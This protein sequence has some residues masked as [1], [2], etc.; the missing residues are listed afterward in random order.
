MGVYKFLKKADEL[1]AKHQRNKEEKP[2][3]ENGH[4]ESNWLVSY[5]DMMTLL[6]GFFI[7]LFSMAKIDETKYEVVK[8]EMAKQFKGSY[9]APA[10]NDIA[11]FIN[12]II[13][14]AKLD[15]HAL[16]TTDPTGV[17]VVFQATL[18]FDTLSSEVSA[19][20]RD[21][22]DRLIE[23]LR[24]HQKKAGKEYKIIVEGHTDSR[25][26]LGGNFPSN[27]E[28]SGARAARVVRFFLSKGFT[29]E[30]LTAIGYGDT[31]PI[32]ESRKSDGTW[33]DDAL[34]KNRR[35]VLR[36]LDPKVDTIPIA[37][38]DKKLTAATVKTT[39]TAP[40]EAPL[41]R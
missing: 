1:Q 11:Q 13:H 14:E 2:P 15:N 22:I 33:D 17:T 18:F 6:C 9:Q 3:A 26:I 32:R 10:S 25:P 7:M 36:I 40:A 24:N 12:Q 39:E 34:A 20:G 29:P 23:G 16:V 21:V 8:Q 27:W 38:V 41:S 19:Q 37:E 4:D 28:L 35:V 31:R 30:R 5:A